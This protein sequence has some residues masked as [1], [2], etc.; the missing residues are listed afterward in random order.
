MKTYKIHYD[1]TGTG[2]A[3]VEAENEDE[4]RDIF[5]AGEATYLKEYYSEHSIDTID[6]VTN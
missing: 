2:T 1:C 6:D 5:F 3:M 4:A